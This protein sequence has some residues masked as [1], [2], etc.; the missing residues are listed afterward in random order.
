MNDITTNPELTAE[1]IKRFEEIRSMV[2]SEFEVEEAFIDRYIPTFYVKLAEDSKKAFL[3]LVEKLGDIGYMPMLRRQEDRVRLWVTSKP[4]TKPNRPIIN[5]IFLIATLATTLLAGYTITSGSTEFGIISNPWIGAPMFALAIM[6]VLGLHEMGHKIAAN[7]NRVEA[8][9]PYFI[10]GPPPPYGLGTFGA[11]IM[12]RELPANRDALFDV[13]SAGPFLGFV[14]A[15]IFTIVGLVFSPVKST[16]EQL[17]SGGYS[18]I[19]IQLLIMVFVQSPMPYDPN[20][21]YY[22]ALHPFAFVGLIGMFVTMLNLFPSGMLDGGHIARSIVGEKTLL[23]LN[24]FSIVLLAV[25]GYY[26]MLFLV[27]IFS[28]FRHPGP[29]DDVSKL[30]T[31]RKL[32]SVVLVAI[33][34]L[35]LLPDWVLVDLLQAI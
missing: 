25:F 32:L 13:G 26:P 18:P 9:M 7:K 34:L 20:L 31:R 16:M 15:L 2:I 28:L 4:K 21:N 3:R 14:A 5:I 30:S 11:V 33:F 35:C 22:I 17:P 8:T 29:L 12:Q 10:P 27:L 19:I 23:V 24:A 1:E 6:A